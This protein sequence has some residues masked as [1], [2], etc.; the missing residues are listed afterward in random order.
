MIRR[1]DAAKGLLFGVVW[2][3]LAAE[4]RADAPKPD[5]FMLSVGIDRYNQNALQGCVNDARNMAQQFQGQKGKIFGQVG[6][7]LLLDRDGNRARVGRELDRI[8]N[9]G[10]AGDFIVVFL[11][12][13]GGNNN[14]SWSFVCQDGA[15]LNDSKLLGVV[16]AVAAQ[17][18]KVLIMIDACF[19]GQLRV[20]A[21]SQ[22]NRNYPQGGGLILMVSSMPSQTSVA[23]GRFSAFA[24][25][26]FE[27]LS[28]H[29]DF[30]GDGYVTLREVRSYAYHRVHDMQKEGRQDGEIDYSLSISENLKLAKATK[31]AGGGVALNPTPRG[32][33]GQLAGTSWHGRE[34]LANYG[35]LAFR[36]MPNSQVI[37]HDTA[38][39]TPGTWS[40]AGN[41]I[42]LRFNNGRT[43]YTGALQGGTLAGTAR[44]GN[45]SWSWTVALR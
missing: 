6:I 17:G 3:L 4:A 1:F 38:G 43:V 33:V 35:D 8:K 34:E 21:R 23:M 41:Q 13:H 27:G 25:A 10:K 15:G 28:G 5:C 7:T 2:A 37:M 32:S 12:G 16:D 45:A 29:A 26:V 9:L 19:A 44:G 24:Q 39:D 11:S 31:P 14:G 22:L 36:F 42:T 20:N 18:K 30:N 40:Q